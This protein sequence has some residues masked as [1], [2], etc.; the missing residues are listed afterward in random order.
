MKINN[1]FS[2]LNISA[3][4]LSVQRRKMDV[5][6]RNLATFLC[7]MFTITP[8]IKIVR[9]FFMQLYFYLLLFLKFI[10]IINIIVFKKI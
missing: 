2:S 3:S 9:K 8:L 1:V 6:A 10:K 7:S 5:I 4:A